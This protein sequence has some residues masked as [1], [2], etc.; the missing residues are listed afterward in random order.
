MHFFD[1][2]IWILECVCVCI[3]TLEKMQHYNLTW[4]E[5]YASR[6]TVQNYDVFYAF[7]FSRNSTLKI[8]FSSFSFQVYLSSLMEVIPISSSILICSLLISFFSFPIRVG[9][10]DN[11]SSIFEI[12]PIQLQYVLT[13]R[14]KTSSESML[15]ME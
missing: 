13:F 3:R 6:P 8:D 2:L 1:L 9:S 5:I 10:T 15:I 11:V 14:I 4:L 7:W 12:P